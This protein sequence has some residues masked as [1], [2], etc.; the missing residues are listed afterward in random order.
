MPVFLCATCGAQQ[1]EGETPPS[2]CIICEDERQWVPKLGQRWV[3]RDE[4]E[5][6][7][8]NAFRKISTDLNPA[9]AERRP[10]ANNRHSNPAQ[11]R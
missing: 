9:A 8:F 2:Q 6:R 11:L 7:H 5:A 1:P 3:T 4:L 10:R